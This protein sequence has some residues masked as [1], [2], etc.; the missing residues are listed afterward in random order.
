MLSNGLKC[1]G[2]SEKRELDIGAVVVAGGNSTRFGSNKLKAI[3]GKKS[4]LEHVLSSLLSLGLREIVLV[5]SER[6]KLY[7]PGINVILE[8]EHNLSG[9]ISTGISACS[10]RRVFL[11]AGDMPFLNPQAIYRQS[12]LAEF[13]IPVWKNGNLEPFHS[14]VGKNLC[15]FLGESH[16]VGEAILA[17]GVVPVPAEAFPEYEFFNINT[18]EDLEKARKILEGKL[19]SEPFHN[20]R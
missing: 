18:P 7:Y 5:V 8:N 4:I 14:V 13:S 20:F 2:N 3:I 11:T 1:T 9:A 10:A 16:R 19:L 15:E 17:S 6:E 12:M